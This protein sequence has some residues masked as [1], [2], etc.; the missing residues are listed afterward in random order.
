MNAFRDSIREKSLHVILHTLGASFSKSNNVGHHFCPY[1]QVVSPDF[2]VLANIFVDFARI[3]DKSKLLGVC[4]HPPCSPASYTTD[5]VDTIFRTEYAK[6]LTKKLQR[7]VLFQLWKNPRLHCGEFM[8]GI[9]TVEADET[10]SDRIKA[11]RTVVISPNTCDVLSNVTSTSHCLFNLILWN[12]S[13]YFYRHVDFSVTYLTR[14]DHLHS[15]PSCSGSSAGLANKTIDLQT[16]VRVDSCPC[17]V[18]T[19]TLSSDLC[20]SAEFGRDVPTP[21]HNKSRA[22]LAFATPQAL[23]EPRHSKGETGVLR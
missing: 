21:A 4:L 1:F 11:S 13:P 12:S 17:C 14:S 2:Q 22:L 15:T 3:F 6:S 20:T 5:V 19:Q 7:M 8:K 16:Q 23:P 9:L 18:A 10:D